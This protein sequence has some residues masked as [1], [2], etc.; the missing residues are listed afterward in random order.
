MAEQATHTAK[1]AATDTLLAKILNINVT[2]FLVFISL[3]STRKN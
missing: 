1:D 3:I 2:D